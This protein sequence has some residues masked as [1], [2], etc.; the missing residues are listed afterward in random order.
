MK[1]VFDSYTDLTNGE[2]IGADETFDNFPMITGRQPGTLAD[3]A[4]R[5]ADRFRY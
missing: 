2:D 5:Y 3:F 1:C 4:R